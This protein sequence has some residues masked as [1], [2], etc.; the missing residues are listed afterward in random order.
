VSY[1]WQA[2]RP[3]EGCRVITGGAK[4]DGRRWKA[5]NIADSS[6]EEKARSSLLERVNNAYGERE[7]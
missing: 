3:R 5:D 1:G 2:E 6:Y 7:I 4:A